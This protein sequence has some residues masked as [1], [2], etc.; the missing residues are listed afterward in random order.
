MSDFKRRFYDAPMPYQEW[1]P[2]PPEAIVQIKNGYGDSRIGPVSSFWWGFE[3]EFG[4]AGEGVIL[5]ARR[6]DRTKGDPT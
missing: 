2:F 4:C 5:F 6:L 3:Q 1:R